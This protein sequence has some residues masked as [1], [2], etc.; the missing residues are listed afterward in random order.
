[1]RYLFMDIMVLVMLA[2]NSYASSLSMR[3]QM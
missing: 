2:I 3:S 1:M